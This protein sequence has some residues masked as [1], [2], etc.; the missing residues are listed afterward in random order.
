[1]K[2]VMSIKPKFAEKILNGTKIFEL[3][4]KSLRKK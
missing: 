3:R 1:M 2:V 4:K